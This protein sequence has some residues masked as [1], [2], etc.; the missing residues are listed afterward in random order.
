MTDF[1]T[2]I[3]NTFWHK[4]GESSWVYKASFLNE[5]ENDKYERT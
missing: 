3:H 2:L 4:S 5:N 1:V